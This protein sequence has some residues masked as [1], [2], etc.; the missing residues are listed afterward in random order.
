MSSAHLFKFIKIQSR[1]T[2]KNV[3][4][5]RTGSEGNTLGSRVQWTVHPAPG[6]VQWVEPLVGVQLYKFF[7]WVMLLYQKC[8]KIRLFG[9]LTYFD[10]YLK[11]SFLWHFC[12]FGDSLKLSCDNFQTENYILVFGHFLIHFKNISTN[13]LP[14]SNSIQVFK[15]LFPQKGSL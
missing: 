6:G 13:I 15:S 3:T 12:W 5:K 9:K 14:I 10:P 4:P 7:I 11:I 8:I 2:F 1:L